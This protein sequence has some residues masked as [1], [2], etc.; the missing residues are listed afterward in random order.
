MVT[1]NSDVSNSE[2]WYLDTGCSNHMTNHREWLVDFDHSK[3]SKVRFADDRIVPVESVG[4]VLIK[5]KD[6]KS[7]LI[8]DVLYVPEMKSNLLSMG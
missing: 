7:A 4:N 8:L 3:K 1:T 5:R 2:T 6:G